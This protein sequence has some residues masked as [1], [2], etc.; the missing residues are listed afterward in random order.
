MQ[1]LGGTRCVIVNTIGFSVDILPFGTTDGAWGS[2][3]FSVIINFH[4]F[5]GDPGP[6]DGVAWSPCRCGHRAVDVMSSTQ[7]QLVPWPSSH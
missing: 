1:G 2:G 7:S 3:V 4:I 6:S 5:F